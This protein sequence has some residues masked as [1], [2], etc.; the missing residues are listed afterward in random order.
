MWLIL[1]RLKMYSP[2]P[3]RLAPGVRAAAR[4]AAC[5]TMWKLLRARC[6]AKV[7]DGSGGLAPIPGRWTLVR[8]DLGTLGPWYVGTSVRWDLGTLGPWRVAAS[9]RFGHCF[10]QTVRYHSFAIATLGVSN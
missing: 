2:G 1:A 4:S 8:W 3:A 5:S 7:G 10:R 9:S 6:Q